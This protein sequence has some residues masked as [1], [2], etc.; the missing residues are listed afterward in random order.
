MPFKNHN[1]LRLLTFD[2]FPA[3]VVHAIFTRLGGLSPAPWN[4]LNVGG[5]VGDTV[6]RVRENRYLSFSALGRERSSLFDVWQVHSPDIVIANAPHPQSESRSE[7]KADGIITD[8]PNVTLF[9]RFADCTPVMLYDKRK[10]VIGLVH[11]GWQGT[12]KQIAGQAVKT[13]QAVYG[14]QPGDIVA[15]IGP[16]IGPDHYEVGSNVLE[17]IMYS[18]GGDAD[19]MIRNRDGKTYFNLWEANKFTLEKCGVAEVEV[20]NICTACHP[21]DWYSH[22]EQKGATGRFGVIIA[23][24]E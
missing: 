7:L 3:C 15:A 16:S 4:S 6:T 8:N 19:R 23:L 2:I 20:S 24:S 9:M 10:K 22:R 12:V 21:E 14:S 1:S 17:Q 13:M 18:F 5:T 11:A